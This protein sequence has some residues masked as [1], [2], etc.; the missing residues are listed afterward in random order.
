MSRRADFGDIILISLRQGRRSRCLHRGDV[1]GEVRLSQGRKVRDLT[2]ASVGKIADTSPTSCKPP[3]VLLH[4]DVECAVLRG[5]KYCECYI[6]RVMPE[7]ELDRKAVPLSN[8]SSKCPLMTYQR[9]ETAM[10]VDS[11]AQK[12]SVIKPDTLP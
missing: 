7:A 3:L 4:F 9:K 6:I 11:V 8:G 5:V 12:R 1:R 10:A 2:P